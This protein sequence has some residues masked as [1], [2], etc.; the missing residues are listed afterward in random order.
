MV[1]SEDERFQEVYVAN[2]ISRADKNPPT[3]CF[4][5]LVRHLVLKG[6]WDSENRYCAK[7]SKIKGPSSYTK[8]YAM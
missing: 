4:P 2:G 6:A 8:D 5:L 1:V 3:C 7:F